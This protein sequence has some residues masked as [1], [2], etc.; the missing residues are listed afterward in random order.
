M[1]NLDQEGRHQAGTDAADKIEEAQK[2]YQS[3][4]KFKDAIKKHQDTNSFKEA[5]KKFQKSEKGQLARQKYY[6][7]KKGTKNWQERNRQ[8][9]LMRR[10]ERWQKDNPERPIS[11]F[12]K[13]DE[14]KE[15]MMKE[16]DD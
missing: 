13:T 11:E 8:Q 14:A 16:N 12:F 5:Q 15:L 3:G 6:Y 7:S 4:P 10:A 2:K 9:K 1:P